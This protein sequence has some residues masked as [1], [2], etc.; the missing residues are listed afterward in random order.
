MKVDLNSK[1][2][3]SVTCPTCGVPAGKVCI[4]HSGG[5]RLEPHVLRKLCATVSTKR[6]WVWRTLPPRIDYWTRVWPL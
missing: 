1:K 4:L 2:M 6:Q 5:L 3:S